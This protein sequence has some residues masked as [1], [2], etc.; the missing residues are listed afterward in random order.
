MVAMRPDSLGGGL[1]IGMKHTARRLDMR[2]TAPLPLLALAL[3]GAIFL[4]DTITP[5]EIAFAV[6][7]VAVVLISMG[8][9]HQRGVIA[10]AAG[11]IALTIVSYA[12]TKSGSPHSG[13]I[14]CAISISV[15]V[16]TTYLGLR[17]VSAE[18]A[19]AE[20]RAQL[21]RM[22]RVMTLGELTASIAHEVN[23]PLTAVVSSGDA[24]L[25]WLAADPPNLDRVRR[26]IERMIRDANRAS[27]VIGR[28]KTLAR[29][30]PAQS[31]RMDVNA[32]IRE[33]LA[34]VRNDL[35]RNGVVLSTELAD[36]LPSVTI[37]P[38]QL[39]QVILNLVVNAV[40]A[41]SGV[42]GRSKELLVAT[43]AVDAGQVRVTVRDTGVGLANNQID[44]VFDAFYT[45]K[46]GGMGIGLAISRTIVEA[47]GGR[48]WATR[49][50][51]PGSTF[52]FT[53]P[54]SARAV[55]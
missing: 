41:L 34:L 8:F 40:D 33:V 11:C 18:V 54:A 5:L 15:I 47:H 9:L 46:D 31:V 24:G 6:F 12:M 38:V 26:A 4:V 51:G 53:L 28:V 52:Q 29:G 35:T 2:R 50:S 44:Q 55:S 22:S 48:V 36:D 42:S 7:Y 30:A 27:Q 14:N 19:A 32:V 45:S 39:Q 16:F 17:S 21:V 23:Q 3:A 10:V 25:R 13:L 20:A 49:N 1:E 37:D 43:S